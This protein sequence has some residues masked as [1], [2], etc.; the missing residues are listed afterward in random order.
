M[1]EAQGA[2]GRRGF[3]LRQYFYCQMWKPR[4]GSEL[5]SGCLQTAYYVCNKN[6]FRV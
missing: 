2:R 3:S 5:P 1:G 4:C 6:Y